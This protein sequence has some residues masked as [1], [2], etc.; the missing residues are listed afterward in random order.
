VPIVITSLGARTDV[1]DA[2]HAWGGVVLHDIINNTHAHKAIDKGADGLIAVAAG[3]GG[4]AGTKSPFALIQEIREWFNGPLALS[5]SIATG[6]AVLACRAMGAD[7]AYIGSAFIATQEARASEA[8]KQCIVD[9]DSDE[10][11]YSN[12]FTGV[13]GNYLK[14]SVRN[15]G[16]D[17][18]N[19]P[20]S[21]PTKMNFG[22]GDSAKKA[23]KD[24]WGCGQGIGA[25]KAVVP[26]AEMVARLKREY[27]AARQRVL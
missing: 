22:G 8:Y 9:S 3:A 14:P 11:V 12:L 19:L 25:V 17:P 18:D 2:V 26:A 24:I 7:F 21:D 5:G 16:M 23:W 27:E 10:I 6:D 4:H 13:H 20:E 15:A 1:N